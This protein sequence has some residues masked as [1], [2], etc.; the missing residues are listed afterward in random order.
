VCNDIW[1]NWAGQQPSRTALGFDGYQWLLDGHAIAGQTAQ[2]YVPV[3]GDVGHQLAC[4]VKVTYTLFPTTVSASSAAVQ[5]KGAA[6]QLADLG[7][8]VVGVGPAKS[9]AAK[10]AD[11]QAA[12]SAGDVA[13]TCGILGAFENEVNAQ[14][15]KKISASEAASLIVDA[16][17]IESVLAC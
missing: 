10:L 6:A 8:A 5:V 13:G 17:R 7:S 1:N 9:L 11:A 2:T 15:G 14:T 16:N 3:A 12:F 4:T